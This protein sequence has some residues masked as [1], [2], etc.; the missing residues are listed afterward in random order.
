[1]EVIAIWHTPIVLTHS[2]LGEFL[3]RLGGYYQAIVE[4]R[5]QKLHSVPSMLYTV[6]ASKDL[7]K[8]YKQSIFTCNRGSTVILEQSVVTEVF[9]DG[10]RL[11]ENSSKMNSTII[12]AH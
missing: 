4:I 11:I 8:N 9:I 10:V 7:K 2:T 5:R 3:A 6:R 1:M 12:V